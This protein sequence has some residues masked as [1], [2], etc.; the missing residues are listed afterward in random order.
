MTSGHREWA[1][2]ISEGNGRGERVWGVVAFRM[3]E[4]GL[5]W[6]ARDCGGVGCATKHS[7]VMKTAYLHI[8]VRIELQKLTGNLDTL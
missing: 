6:A 5:Q 3:L 2:R 4:I 7:R 8:V 1:C